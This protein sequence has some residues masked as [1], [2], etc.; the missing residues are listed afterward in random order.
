MYVALKVHKLS[1]EMGF[2]MGGV[3]RVWTELTDCDFKEMLEVRKPKSWLKSVSAFAN[4][5][6]GGLVFG[7]SDEKTVVGLCVRSPRQCSYA[8]RLRRYRK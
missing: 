7:V 3:K 2:F 4:E 6:G 1:I 5:R 8:P